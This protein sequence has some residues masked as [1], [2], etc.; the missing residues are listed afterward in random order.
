M[1]AH[2][3]SGSRVPAT[4]SAA[5]ATGASMPET[6]RLPLEYEAGTTI[7]TGR[8]DRHETRNPAEAGSRGADD[9]IRTRDL[10]LGKV[11]L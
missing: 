11:A 8:E 7:S 6:G 10:H 5:T 3:P 2:R 1:R 9:E 4:S